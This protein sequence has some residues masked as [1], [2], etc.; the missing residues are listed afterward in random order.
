MIKVNN[1]YTVDWP[2]YAN[3][4]LQRFAHLS[5]AFVYDLQTWLVHNTTLN[6]VLCCVVFVSTL[7]EMQHDTRIDLDPI[8]M[9]LCV[10][11]L[12]LDVKKSPP[13]LVINLCTSRINATQG[14]AS[15]CEPVFRLCRQSLLQY[16]YCIARKFGGE[17]NLAVWRFTF[18]A[19]KLKSANISY[20]HVYIL[21]MAIPY[22]QS[23]NLIP[24]NISGCT[25]LSSI[26]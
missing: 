22:T 18:A 11:L 19:V 2:W 8:L 26:C 13:F 21:C 10:T 7:I 15:L 6:N 5:V 4:Q 3:L 14:L 17:L 16:Y 25:V 20:L 23:P 9:F 24:T 1:H 12:G